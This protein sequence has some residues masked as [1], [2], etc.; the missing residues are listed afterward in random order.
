MITPTI[1][2]D[3]EFNR[4]SIKARL[5]FIGLISNADDDG[6]LRGDYRSLRRLIFGFD[7]TDDEQWL[8]ELK[9]FKTLHFFE[10]EG[11]F[12]VHLLNWDKYQNQREDRRQ[13]SSYPVCGKCQT[14]DGQ[15]PAKVSKLSKDKE[16]SKGYKKFLEAREQIGKL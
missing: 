2:E 3:P 4:L 10:K 11:E 6:Y 13:P 15:V 14:S 9:T 8:G 16:G 5:A 12:F 7:D 1:W